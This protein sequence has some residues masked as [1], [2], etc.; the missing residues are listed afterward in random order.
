MMTTLVPRTNLVF[1]PVPPPK[2]T[3]TMLT[4]ST[5]HFIYSHFNH[6]EDNIMMMMDTLK[7][8][9]DKGANPNGLNSVSVA[10]PASTIYVY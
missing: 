10:A 9:L 3:T 1:R 4:P 6:R 8:L 2:V 7:Y 5:L